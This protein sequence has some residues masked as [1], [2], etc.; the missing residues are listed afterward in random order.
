MLTQ[1]KLLGEVL[2]TKKVG[3]KSKPHIKLTTTIRI[4]G[5]IKNYFSA[6]FLF[7]VGTFCLCDPHQALYLISSVANL[8]V[9]IQVYPYLRLYLYVQVFC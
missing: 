5:T 7:K 6:I 1:G 3:G 2:K 4:S 8:P 9:L